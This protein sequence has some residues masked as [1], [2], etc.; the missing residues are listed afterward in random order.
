MRLNIRT[1]WISQAKYNLSERK[2]SNKTTANTYIKKQAN[3]EVRRNTKAII[4][5]ELEVAQ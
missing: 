5:Y 4:Q 3:R 1:Y 2:H